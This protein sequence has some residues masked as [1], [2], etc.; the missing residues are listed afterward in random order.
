MHDRPES[1]KRIVLAANSSWNIV[2]FRSGLVRAL[3]EQGYEPVVIAPL[4]PA[5]EARME[6]LGVE[7]IP[8]ELDRSG[9]DP[10]ADL[11]LLWAHRKTLKRL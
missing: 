2:N 6:Q 11:L 4:D 9:L 8:V 5:A 10:I 1:P 3:R 7:R